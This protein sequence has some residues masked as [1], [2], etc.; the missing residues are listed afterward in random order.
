PGHA[1]EALERVVQQGLLA[2]NLDVGDPGDAEGNATLGVRILHADLDDHV[3]E[4]H[5]VDALEQRDAERTT[6]TDDAIA[7]TFV[8]DV[9]AEAGEDEHLVGL[10]DVEHLGDEQH[11][12]ADECDQ[13]RGQR[14]PSALRQKSEQNGGSG[15]QEMLRAISVAREDD[16]LGTP[17]ADA[18]VR[19]PGTSIPVV[20]RSVRN[21]ASTT[22]GW[23]E[24]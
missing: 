14:D 15:H 9:R 18:W 21:T 12:R 6:A 1:E 3:G 19:I 11:Q 23:A 4:V 10:A 13:D 7:A 8:A 22:G 20:S 24:A 5:A 16:G 17:G 2:G